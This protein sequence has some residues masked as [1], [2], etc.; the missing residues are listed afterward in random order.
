MSQN[1]P[2]ATELVDVTQIC[3]TFP[4]MLGIQIQRENIHNTLE[5]ILESEVELVSLEGQEGIGKT[6]ILAQ[7]ARGHADRCISMFVSPSSRFVYDPSVQ[8]SDLCNQMQWILRRQ[9]IPTDAASDPSLYRQLVMELQRTARRSGKYI[10]FI[11]DGLEDLA[12]DSID[13]RGLLELLPFGLQKFRF[14]FSGNAEQILKLAQRKLPFKGVTIPGFTLDESTRF[15]ADVSTPSE[16][17]TEFFKACKGIPAHLAAMKRIIQSGVK[18]ESLLEK[19]PESIRA[20]FEIEWKAVQEENELQILSLALVSTER[21][22]LSTKDIAGILDVEEFAV[23]ASLCQLGFISLPADADTGV[24]FVSEAFRRF[25]NARLQSYEDRVRSRVID[26]LLRQPSS[27]DAMAYLPNYLEESGRLQELLKFLSPDYFAAM[28][29]TSQSLAPVQI[30]AELGV[31]AA[32]KLDRDEALLRFGLQ[33]AVIAELDGCEI[34]RSEV[35]ARMALDDYDAALKLAQTAILKQDRLRLLVLIAKLQKEKGLTPEA[36]LI[37]QIQKLYTEVEPTALGDNLLELA[38]DLMYSLPDLGL[39]LLDRVPLSGRKGKSIDWA[40]ARISIDLSLRETNAGSFPGA[41]A[42]ELRKKIK[43]PALRSFSSS[44]AFLMGDYSAADVLREIERL[45]SPADQLFLLQEWARNA[46][47]PEDAGRVLEHGLLLSIRSTEYTPHATHLRK[48]ATPLPHLRDDALRR[49]LI[50]KFDTLKATI[51]KLG[52]TEDYVRLQLKLT[53]AEA[54]HDPDAANTRLLELFYYLSGIT[55][56]ETKTACIARVVAELDVFAE[57][58]SLADVKEVLQTAERDLNASVE[59]LLKS[60]ANHDEVCKRAVQ[61]L[62]GHRAD[63]AFNIIGRFNTQNRRDA[64]YSALFEEV[65]LQA[66]REI[67]YVLLGDKLDLFADTFQRDI[68]LEDL[69]SKVWSFKNETIAEILPAVKPLISR[70]ST[71]ADLGL[72]YRA[73]CSALSILAQ[74]DPNECAAMAGRAANDL[75]ETWQRMELGNGK[76]DAGFRISSTLASTRRALAIEYLNRADQ[77]R[78]GSALDYNDQTSHKCIQLAIR[79]YA[80]LLP[81]KFN[82]QSDLDKLIAQIERI[83][84]DSARIALW[85]DLSLRCFQ[86]DSVALGKQIVT[87]RIKPGL[88]TIL[89]RSNE[90]WKTIL[91]G[92]APALYQ[93]H[94]LSTLDLIA[95]LEQNQRDD[96]LGEIIYFIFRRIPPRDSYSNTSEL[97]FPD[98]SYEDALDVCELLEGI[99]DDSEVYSIIRNLVDSITC[100][101]RRKIFSTQQRAD[102]AQKLAAICTRKFPNPRFIKH[103]GYKIVA[104]AQIAKLARTRPFPWGQLVAESRLL[105]NLA[106]I[107][108]VL[109]AL[110]ETCTDVDIQ[111]RAKLLREAKELADQIPSTIDRISRYEFIAD[112]ARDIDLVLCKQC[113]REALDSTKAVHRSRA[114]STQRRLVDLAYGIDTALAG[115]LADSLDDDEARLEARDHLQLQEERKKIAEGVL[116][117]AAEQ[118]DAYRMSDNMWVLLGKLNANRV[119]TLAVGRTRTFVE[120]ASKMPL[121]HSFSTFSWVIENAVRRRAQAAEARTLMRGLFEASLV[122]CDLAH[123]LGGRAAGKLR[124]AIRFTPS[125]DDNRS[126]VIRS[127]DRE[128]ALAFLKDWIGQNVS[129]YLKICDPYFGPEDLEALQMVLASAPTVFVSVLTSKKHQDACPAGTT[130]E[131]YFQQY[132]RKIS[133]QTP[134]RNDIWVIGTPSGDLPIHERWWLSYKNGLRMGTSYNSIGGKRESEISILSEAEAEVREAEVDEFISFKKREH[135]GQRLSISVFSI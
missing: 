25:A 125:R 93:S 106:D 121:T 40:L 49:S 14:L 80:G 84:S 111:E 47:N 42:E 134:P 83:L 3:T 120:V 24:T 77:L 66:P 123:L 1:E 34:S 124:D 117:V 118:L 29:G 96:A 18:P 82:T 7:F 52:P 5:S 71:I 50:G 23:R 113:I 57:T 11:V 10:Y 19:P 103:D 6:T 127:G 105:P 99:D 88:E 43:D 28:I 81:Q 69:L 26:S 104:G 27:E 86:Y 130:V 53:E 65:L 119:E 32:L 31:K 115:T 38:S 22:K 8:S 129:K 17:T 108:F 44:I 67:P 114:K 110:A 55:D 59:K 45:S 41:A 132:W 102:I 33:E 94:K 30:K 98:L 101:H 92:C 70:I 95:R 90:E 36:E 91:V 97:S 85:T 100:K 135:N 13:V 133:D 61:A 131:M 4:T 79:A 63:L 107:G 62:A 72:R 46:P 64:G 68:A 116:D 15:F 112:V 74:G 75:E 76:I 21:R 60:T 54:I 78:R 89:K 126:F 87:E 37:E 35:N 48:L 12:K 16:L 9:E 73:N 20:S 58:K 122:G 39:Q 109:T 51:E 128:N 56:L 2:V